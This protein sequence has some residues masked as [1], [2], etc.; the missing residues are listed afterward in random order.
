MMREVVGGIDMFGG[1]AMVVFDVSKMG[2]SN[3]DVYIEFLQEV[4]EDFLFVVFS[5][6]ELTAANAFN[7]NAGKFGAKTMPFKGVSKANIFKFVDCVFDLNRSGT[8][9]EL[10]RLILADEDAV[11]LMTMLEYG[12]RSI[13]YAK[14]DSPA[15]NKLAPFVKSKVQRQAN[16]FTEEQLINIYGRFYELDRDLKFGGVPPEV[17]VPLAIESVL[18]L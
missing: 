8:Y 17:T 18:G 2:R 13:S 3:V 6:K 5:A 7:K 4:P 9:K 11:Y 12:L 10:Q 15:F 16:N 14:F 1:K